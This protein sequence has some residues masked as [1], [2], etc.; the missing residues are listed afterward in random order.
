MKTLSTLFFD[1]N[2]HKYLDDSEIAKI[3]IGPAKPPLIHQL[4]GR[5]KRK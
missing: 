3:Q 1:D 5:N 2:R 4:G